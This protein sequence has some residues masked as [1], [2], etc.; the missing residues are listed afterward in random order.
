MRTVPDK[1]I[2]PL[3]FD[4][5]DLFPCPIGEAGQGIWDLFSGRGTGGGNLPVRPPRTYKK[6]LKKMKKKRL[7]DFVNDAIITK[8]SL[9]AA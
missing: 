1:K 8:L 6:K 4:R 7:T 2:E 9:R 3:T 5:G